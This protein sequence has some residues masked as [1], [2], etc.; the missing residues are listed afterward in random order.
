M[1]SFKDN[2]VAFARSFEDTTAIVIAPRFLAGIV[3]SEEMP[4]GK[5]VWKDTNLQLP[6]GMPSVWQDAI[7]NQA[8]ETDGTL[9]IG[10]ALSYFPGS[11]LIGKR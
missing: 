2:V 1:G 5:Q 4:L 7:T 6:D 10:E 9:A 11:L 8:V 3:K